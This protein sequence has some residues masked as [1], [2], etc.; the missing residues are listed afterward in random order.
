MCLIFDI[1]SIPY[2]MEAAFFEFEL[3]ENDPRYIALEHQ[4]QRSVYRET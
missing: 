1:C 4:K 3:Y 2:A